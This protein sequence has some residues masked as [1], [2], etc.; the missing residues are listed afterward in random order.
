MR[1]FLDSVSYITDQ[2]LEFKT[3]AIE[4][5]EMIEMEKELDALRSKV[6][7]LTEEVCSPYTAPPLAYDEPLE[8][9][10]PASRN[11]S[12]CHRDQHLEVSPSHDAAYRRP[13]RRSWGARGETTNTFWDAAQ[14]T[15]IVIRHRPSKVSCSGSCRRR[16]RSYNSKPSWTALKR[17]TRPSQEMYVTKR[18]QSCSLT[19]MCRMSV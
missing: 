5:D 1:A 8:G 13:S 10:S 11:R 17:R 14:F 19:S 6:D 9:R 15:Y 2:P 4:S 16:S 18:L 7:T 3:G 12:A